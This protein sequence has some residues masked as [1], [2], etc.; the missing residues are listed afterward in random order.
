MFDE[1]P[2][3]EGVRE[4]AGW[5]S[6]GEP[7]QM[8]WVSEEKNVGAINCIVTLKDLLVTACRLVLRTLK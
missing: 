4:G 8:L 3:D 5:G 1:E 2:V 6:E 7:P